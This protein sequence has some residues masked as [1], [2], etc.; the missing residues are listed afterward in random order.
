MHPFV[1]DRAEFDRL[2]ARAVTMLGEY[3]RESARASRSTASCPRT[4]AVA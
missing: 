2:G 1:E 4:F 3:L